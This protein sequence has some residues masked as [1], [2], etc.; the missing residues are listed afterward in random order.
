M[1]SVKDEITQEINNSINNQ[2]TPNTLDEIIQGKS[3]S[4]NNLSDKNKQEKTDYCKEL[5]NIAYKT[6]LLN[7]HEIVPDVNNTNNNTL[8]KYLQDETCAN[9]KENWSKLD[10]TQKVKKLIHHVEVLEKKFTL[11]EEEAN[12][13]KKYLL[14][15][16][17]RK[18]LTKV[19]DVHYDKDKGVISDIPN[20]HFDIINRVFALKKD[21][22]HISTV[23]CLPQENKSKAKTIK[24]LE[25]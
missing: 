24:I 10:K 8:S 20:L 1:T 18:A 17:E 5:K 25:Q 11:N 14:K 7:G 22:K 13:C 9:Q 2:E 12:K 21:E 19:K 15:C 23:K 16:L 4:K 6:M 3:N